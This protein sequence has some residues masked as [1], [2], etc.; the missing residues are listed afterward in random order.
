MK[1]KLITFGLSTLLIMLAFL[2]A[3][4]QNSSSIEMADA[5]RSSGKIYVVIAVIALVFAGIIA[6]LLRIDRKLNALEKNF[7]KNNSK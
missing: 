4:G 3:F 2:P 7:G 5:W 1:S 6:F